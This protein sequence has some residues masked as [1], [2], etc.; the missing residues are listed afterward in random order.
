MNSS[1]L[2]SIWLILLIAG[3]PQLSETVYTPSLPEIAKVL[4]TSNSM[5]EHTL[6]IYL[7]GFSIGTFFWGWLSDRFGRKPSVLIGLIVFICGCIS[8]FYSISI[9]MLMV[10]RFVQA[11]GGSIGSV[12][13][14]AICRDSFRGPALGR[15]YSSIGTA[16]AVFPAIGPVTG[17][18]IAEH[19][20]W[21]GIFLFLMIFAIILFA[22]IVIF[23]PETHKHDS[24]NSLSLK[25]VAFSLIKSKKVIGF[26]IIVAICNG[27]GFSYFAEGS[28]YLIS[29]LGLSPSQYGL[30]FFFIAVSAMI[31]GIIS[32][33]LHNTNSSYVIM[34]YGIVVVL[35]STLLFSILIALSSNLFHFSNYMLIGIVILSQ[36]I[37][38]LGV[39]IVTSN[40][41]ALSLSDYTKSKGTASSLFG[42]FYYSLISI[43]TLIMGL[44]H[45]GTLLPMPFYFFGL[46]VL[47]ILVQKKM[48][49]SYFEI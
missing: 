33:R 18:F 49:A 8:C 2:P 45:N 9:T 15:A 44:L 3:L 11:F 19:F 40:A 7:F 26:G 22:F 43:F 12:L 48:V 21:K 20:G 32:K 13:G 41:L 37:T 36:M 17:G 27:I 25:E 28:F 46:S 29:L 42:F 16:L 10:S 30:T 1:I 4:K 5:V 47:M 31:G 14:Q 39:C 38:M 24:N 23:L 34:R 6:T 35:I